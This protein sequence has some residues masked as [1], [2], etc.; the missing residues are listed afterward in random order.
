MPEPQGEKDTEKIKLDPYLTLLAKI[1]CIWCILNVKSKLNI[2][3]KNKRNIF[4][5]EFNKL[6]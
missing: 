1:Y 4:N 5:I 2:S 6:S 3:G